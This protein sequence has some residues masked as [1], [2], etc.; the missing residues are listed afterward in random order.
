MGFFRA[1]LL[2]FL[3]LVLACESNP[4]GGDDDGDYSATAQDAD[5]T[6]TA[7][8]NIALSA[9]QAS[10]GDA[11]S[12]VG[13]EAAPALR[14]KSVI[15]AESITICDPATVPLPA[16][17]SSTRIDGSDAG[18]CN[19]FFSGGASNAVVRANCTDYNDGDDGAR[20]SLLG[21]VGVQGSTAALQIS[22]ESLTVTLANERNCTAVLNFS[23]QVT[24]N[25]AGGGEMAVDGCVRICGESYSLT[26]SEIF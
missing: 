16:G 20:A 26:G 17:D 5:D 24:T 12:A 7:A 2:I 25:E 19:V 9:F 18:S 3:S 22:S 14:L 8:G 6:A 1:I 15:T 4:H 13:E 23:A 10:F 11:P 21:L